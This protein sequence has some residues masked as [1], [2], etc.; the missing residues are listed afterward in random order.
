MKLISFSLT[1]PQFKARTKHV[2]R[3][4]GWLTVKVGK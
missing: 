2:T 4:T 3:R 1:T